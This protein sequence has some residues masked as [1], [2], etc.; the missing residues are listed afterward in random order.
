MSAVTKLLW[1]DTPA[2]LPRTIVAGDT[3]T[4]PGLWTFTGP[5]GTAFQGNVS[6]TGNLNVAG[7]II[8]SGTASVVTSDNFIDLNT[9]YTDEVVP[10]SGGIDVTN[11]PVPGT[12]TLATI[13]SFDF[14]AGTSGLIDAKF[15]VGKPGNPFP[16]G[17]AVYA[18]GDVIEFGSLDAGVGANAGLYVIGAVN[19]GTDV[20]GNPDANRTQ[21]VVHGLASGSLPVNAPFAHNQFTSG[22][23]NNGTLARVRL[24]VLL[25]SGGQVTR[26]TNLLDTI[27]LGTFATG[28]SASAWVSDPLGSTPP[29]VGRTE[30]FYTAL[31]PADNSWD[32]AGNAGTNAASNFVGTTDA[33]DLVLR[34]NNT[35]RLRALSTGG[36]EVKNGPVNLT[37]TGTA[38]ELRFYEPSGSG[39]NY[40]AF[41]AQAQT[42]D[43]TYTLPSADGANGQAL[44]T[45]GSGTLAWTNVEVPTITLTAAVN[46]SMGDVV[47]VNSAGQA[48]LAD[49]NGALNPV[50]FYTVGVVKAAVLAGQPV[51]IYANVLTRVPTRASAV[52]LAADNGKPVFLD[53]AVP[54]QVTLGQAPAGNAVVRVGILVGADGVTT[55]PDVLIQL[56]FIAVRM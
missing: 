15:S 42:G 10:A 39:S 33:V 16:T 30:L 51:Q 3:V 23:S 55:T 29:P 54:G 20:N 11:Q 36:V 25:S 8:T 38:T 1:L 45:N 14:L 50:R 46:L 26:S 52:F 22:T 18:V 6:I 32:V 28:Y 9:G 47:S 19:D 35:E 24:S 4:A 37:N 5:G 44:T 40:T 34:A 56:Q 13:Y 31:D 49:T 27:P 48:Q 21:F 53:A 41:K 7:A 2:G 43:V 12:I 17:S